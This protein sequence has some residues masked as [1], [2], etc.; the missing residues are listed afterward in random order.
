MLACHPN[1]GKLPNS[2]TFFSYNFYLVPRKRAPDN[3]NLINNIFEQ[4][5]VCW[6]YAFIQQNLTSLTYMFF[7]FHTFFS[8]ERE[9]QPRNVKTLWKN[10]SSRLGEP[11]VKHTITGSSS[12]TI[13]DTSTNQTPKPSSSVPYFHRKKKI[14]S[15]IRYPIIITSASVCFTL[16]RFSK[17]SK[18]TR[19]M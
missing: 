15:A 7:I 16:T 12:W 18:I 3:I 11:L 17:A 14:H 2:F 10:V 19:D 8:Y 9:N 5:F 1:P 4:N 13:Q 6:M